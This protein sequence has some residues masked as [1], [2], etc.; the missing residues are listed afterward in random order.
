M[1][2]LVKRKKP[3]NLLPCTPF[4]LF[5]AY[6]DSV[7]LHPKINTSLKRTE[8]IVAINYIL[9]S[10]F[11]ECDF[12]GKWFLLVWP[13]VYFSYPNVSFSWLASCRLTM[14]SRLLAASVTC[15][16]LKDNLEEQLSLGPRAVFKPDKPRLG[17]TE[18]EILHYWVSTEPSLII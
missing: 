14:D 3:S 9:R 5:N 1:S 4:V 6:T 13:W 16:E 7:V 10:S 15:P 18:A 12:P 11:C 2:K 8:G 17:Q